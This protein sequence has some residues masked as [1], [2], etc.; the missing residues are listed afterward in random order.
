MLDGEKKGRFGARRRLDVPF[1]STF[2]GN[3]GDGGN[4]KERGRK[5]WTARRLGKKKR[6]ASRGRRALE[7]LNGN[8]TVDGAR[9]G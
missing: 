1:L 9:R 3:G 8:L 5:S 2:W 6:P 7:K 4:G